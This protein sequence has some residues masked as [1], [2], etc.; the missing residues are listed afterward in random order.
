MALPETIKISRVGVVPAAAQDG[1]PFPMLMG[2]HEVAILHALEYW[3]VA[4]AA[5]GL[6]EMQMMVWK[7]TDTNPPGGEASYAPSKSAIWSKREHS[8]FVTESIKCGNSDYL[9]LPLPIVL[10]RAPR[11]IHRMATWVNPRIEFR[12][13]Y[14]LQEVSDKELAELMVKDHA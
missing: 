6:C 1:E 13:Y 4:T 8:S 14:R 2:K 7:K 5:A 9:L 11:L 3:W 12:L 10:I